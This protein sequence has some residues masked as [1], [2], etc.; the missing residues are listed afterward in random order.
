MI[1]SRT[2]F[3]V[4]FF[5]G[6]TDYAPWYQEH[7][8]EI[9]AATINKYCY[10][11]CR[12]LPH[13]FEHKNRIVWSKVEMV[14]EIDEIEHPSVRETLRFLNIQEGVEIHHDGD[15]PARSGLGSSSAFTVSLL[16]A[17]YALKGTMVSKM[18]LAKQAIHVE[19]NLMKECVGVQ[20]QIQTAFGGLNHIKI[21]PNHSFVVNPL[22]I[23]A[24][25][26]QDLEGSLMLFFT[27]VSRTASDI[28]KSQV[29]SIANKQNELRLMQDL[30]AEGIKILT[31]SDDLND[32]GCL[33]H[34]GWLLKRSLTNKISTDSINDVYEKAMKAGALGGKVLGAGGG[35]FMLFF[36]PKDYQ[37]AV[38]LALQDLVYVPVEFD[39]EGSK[40]IFYN[41]SEHSNPNNSLSQNKVST[42]IDKKTPITL[43][44]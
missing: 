22:I 24:K 1:I 5:G 31:Q 11:N 2:P 20:D 42:N 44:A 43:R 19:Q 18:E 17:L 7:G 33:L 23:S 15:L 32:F 27:G 35:G 4:S 6:G 41:P 14:K 8:G 39:H 34:Q 21:H 25:K 16:N 38:K 30:V 9:L 28:A 37:N 29:Q 12:Y 26:M 13:F 40:I 3:R 10:I 36:V